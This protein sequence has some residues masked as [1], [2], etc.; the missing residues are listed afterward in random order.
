MV[1]LNGCLDSFNLRRLSLSL[2]QEI[3]RKIFLETYDRIITDI[4][5]D[6]P[7][8]TM[9]ATSRQVG[10]KNLRILA[11]Y[12]ISCRLILR[13]GGIIEG[14]PEGSMAFRHDCQHDL[15]ASKPLR[16]AALEKTL[17]RINN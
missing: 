15:T 6:Q 3:K 9:S 8:F 11:G 16:N 10:H 1:V 14:T 12:A 7:I 5:Q 4:P 2:C 13:R 17:N